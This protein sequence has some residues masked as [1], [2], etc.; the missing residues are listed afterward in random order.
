[1]K[2]LECIGPTYRLDKL[3]LL[4]QGLLIFDL[5]ARGPCLDLITLPLQFLDLALQGI[6]ELFLLGLV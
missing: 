5:I 2:G 6:F 4:E 1:M 3:P